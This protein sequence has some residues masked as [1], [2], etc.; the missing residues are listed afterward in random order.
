MAS[1]Y[2]RVSYMAL[3]K[4]TTENT[5][6]TPDVFIPFM[7][8]DIVTEWSGTFS[9]AIVS[10]R[11]VNY[12]PVDHAIPAPEGSVSLHVEPAFFGHFLLGAG[13]AISS[14]VYF[15]I[16]SLSA[17]FTVGETVTGGTSTE[18]AT[19]VKTSTEGDYVLVSSPSG[20]FTD[21]ETITGG[22]SGSTATLTKM[23]AQAIG[24][25]VTWPQD[26]LATTYTVEFGFDGEAY[27]YT[28]VRFGEIAWSQS[29]N[30]WT[31]DVGVTARTE[32]KMAR[33]TAITSSGAGSQTITVDQTTGLA[34]SDT[35]K[36]YRPGTGFQDFSASSVKTHTIDAVS[37][38]TA[39][40]VTNL[41][42][43]TAVGD[44]ILLAPQTPSYTGESEFIWAGGTEARLG[45][46]I[47]TALAAS[48]DCIEDFNLTITNNLEPRHC[49]DG[50]NTV[51]RFPGK[52]YTA[53]LD[54]TGTIMKTY[55]NMEFLD[56][57]R[58]NRQFALQL[59]STADALPNAAD[60][61]YTLDI[62]IPDAR[63]NPFMANISEDDIIGQDMEFQM[64][65][66]TSD[67]YFMKA[68]LVNE[69]TSY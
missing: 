51:N 11:A 5:A 36:L 27:R 61:N 34:A 62:R 28:G 39:F 42:T 41:E 24:H 57:M 33:V 32:F 12:R 50:A 31:A 18:T 64:F 4:E 46:S 19:V 7:S 2:S 67:G 10:N 23:D 55:E 59:L 22:T 38:E 26:S 40:T 16:T 25:E 52:V 43:S 35:V 9:Q 1:S 48:G 47:T 20:E 54:G 6:V 66:S 65:N 13:G 8:E 53:G 21:G 44:L 14:G 49:A 17:D 29:D 30:V 15:P 37:N 58:S 45:T 56:K 60:F 63:H 3:K 69:E 68:L